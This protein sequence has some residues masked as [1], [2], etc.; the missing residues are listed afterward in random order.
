MSMG[1]TSSVAGALC[2]AP[3]RRLGAVRHLPGGSLRGLSSCRR[4]IEL[5]ETTVVVHVDEI[6]RVHRREG[7]DVV[8]MDDISGSP[9]R[10]DDQGSA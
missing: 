7:S 3:T 4:V 5:V 6:R 9:S 1:A 10:P 2:L 8:H